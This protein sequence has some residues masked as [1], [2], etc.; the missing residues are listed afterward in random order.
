MSILCFNFTFR[1]KVCEEHNYMPLFGSPC[2]VLKISL[3]QTIPE[4]FL[5]NNS[6]YDNHIHY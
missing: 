5:N 2:C 6:V 1:Q 4:S 3:A